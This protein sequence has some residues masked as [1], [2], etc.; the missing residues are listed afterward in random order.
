MSEAS[1][2]KKA[3]HDVKRLSQLFKSV[4]VLAE[5]A[6]NAAGMERAADE[7]E[8][9]VNEFREQGDHLADRITELNAELER[10]APEAEE[11]AQL[12]LA[13]AGLED[14][15]Q[16]LK[17]ARDAAM[18]EASTIREKAQEEAD[19]AIAAAKSESAKIMEGAKHAAEQVETSLD[20]KREAIIAANNTLGD[21]EEKIAAAKENARHILG[22]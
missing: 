1:E 22:V 18:Q 21:L 16:E 20:E 6:D 13:K 5:V 14:E 7:A 11:V 19:K 17:E 2:L 8:K 4:D 10:L 12:E 3:A 9:R 15:V